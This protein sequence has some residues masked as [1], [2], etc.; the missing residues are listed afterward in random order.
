MKYIIT[1][2]KEIVIGNMFHPELA[3]NCLGKVISAGRIK[4]EKG[5]LKVFGKSNSYDIDS[6]PEDI[7]IIIKELTSLHRD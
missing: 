7:E 5:K 4:I 1:D 6:K 3:M 2:K